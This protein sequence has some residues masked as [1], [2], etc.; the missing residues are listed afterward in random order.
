MLISA[1]ASE[2]L[3]ARQG[4]EADAAASSQTDLGARKSWQEKSNVLHLDDAITRTTETGDASGHHKT[5]M[6]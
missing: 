3:Q 6:A 2:K 5:A 4:T 1:V